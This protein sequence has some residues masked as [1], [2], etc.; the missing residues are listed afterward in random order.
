[1][2]DLSETKKDHEQ[3]ENKLFFIDVR[4]LRDNRLL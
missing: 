2:F 3:I 4:G 1:M